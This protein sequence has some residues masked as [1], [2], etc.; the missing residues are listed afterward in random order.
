MN[1]IQY[2]YS[3]MRAENSL[4]WPSKFFGIRILHVIIKVKRDSCKNDYKIQL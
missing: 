1:C 3:T 2:T 4:L